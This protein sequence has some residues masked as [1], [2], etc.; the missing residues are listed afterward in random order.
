[1]TMPEIPGFNSLRGRT[2]PTESRLKHHL[3][4]RL[5]P[6]WLRRPTIAKERPTADGFDNCSPIATKDYWVENRLGRTLT[7]TRTSVPS[8]RSNTS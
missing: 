1:M 2:G 3:L 7:P 5:L 6:Q 8:G 4:I